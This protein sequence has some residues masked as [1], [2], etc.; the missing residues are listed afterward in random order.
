MPD[1]PDPLT[2]ALARF[3]PTARLD[4]DEVLFRAGRASAPNGRWWKRAAALL[5]VTQAATLA[6]WLRPAAERSPV[7]V[8]VVPS[9]LEL[10]PEP[11]PLP[12]D[13]YGAF[14]RAVRAD[15][16]PPPAPAP[17]GPSADDPPLSVASGYRGQILE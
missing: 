13:S 12:P 7:P 10:P 1:R 5:V 17:N 15:G 4:R 11:A 14:I 3:T 8:P 6:V 2:D 16:L 9:A